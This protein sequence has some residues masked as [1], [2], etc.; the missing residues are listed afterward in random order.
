MI[1]IIPNIYSNYILCQFLSPMPELYT[2]EHIL[3]TNVGNNAF[4]WEKRSLK[5]GKNPLLYIPTLISGTIED[6][7]IGRD[8]VFEEVENGKLRSCIGLEHMVQI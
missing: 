3:D 1:Y 2:Q 8:I 4:A 6:V 5:Y 7:K